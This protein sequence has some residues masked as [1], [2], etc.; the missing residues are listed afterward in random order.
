M[1]LAGVTDR[2]LMDGNLAVA[3]TADPLCSVFLDDW[4]D[5]WSLYSRERRFKIK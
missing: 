1:V 3:L 4:Q 2:L 5:V